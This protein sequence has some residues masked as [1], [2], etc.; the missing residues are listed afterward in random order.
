MKVKI[1]FGLL[2]LFIIKIANGQETGQETGQESETNEEKL[3]KGIQP[4]KG[5]KEECTNH[6]VTDKTCCY[7]TVKF[8]YNN[9]YACYPTKKED[10]NAIK[11]AIKELKNEFKDSKSISIK[12]NSTSINI[13]FILLSLL[14]FI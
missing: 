10:L 2:F 9:Y 11:N 7:M 3:C 5:I 4:T 1:I 13:S 14:F 8:K 6:I 12:C